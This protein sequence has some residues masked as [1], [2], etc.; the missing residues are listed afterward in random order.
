M[1]RAEVLCTGNIQTRSY[2]HYLGPTRIR[3]SWVFIEEK[4]INYDT[5]IYIERDS[6]RATSYSQNGYITPI[7]W[8]VK[9][10]RKTSVRALFSK[11][12]QEL[13]GKD[14]TKVPRGL[15]NGIGLILVVGVQAGLRLRQVVVE[16]RIVWGYKVMA[17]G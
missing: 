8:T 5:A 14:M 2:W 13:P 15:Y 7:P 12:P 17:L 10:R 11:Q 6:G 4:Y 3:S 1:Q 9:Q 16:E